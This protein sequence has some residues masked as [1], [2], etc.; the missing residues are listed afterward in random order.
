[1][2]FQI[3]S[4]NQIIIPLLAL[5]KYFLKRRYKYEFSELETTPD[6]VEETSSDGVIQAEETV[7]YHFQSYA[8]FTTLEK[9]ITNALKVKIK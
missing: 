2:T 5:D 9:D 4:Y 8:E 6:S 7:I 1:V 3:T